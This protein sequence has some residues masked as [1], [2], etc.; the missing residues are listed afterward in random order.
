MTFE[1][2]RSLISDTIFNISLNAQAKVDKDFKKDIDNSIYIISKSFLILDTILNHT[3]QEKVSDRVFDSQAILW[4]GGNSLIGSLQLIRQGYTLEP[5]FLMRYAIENLAMV[6]SFHTEN[7]ELYYQKFNNGDLSGE[8]CVGEAR[9][10]VKQIGPIYGLLSEVT[11][12]SK[13]TLGYLYMLERKTVLI[14]GGVTD[15]TLHRVKMNLAI[16]QFLSNIYWSSS[17]LIFSDYLDKYTFWSKD[18]DIMKWAPKEEEKDIYERSLSLFQEAI[19]ALTQK[20]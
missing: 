17:E 4:Q 8:K 9:K 19:S 15:T 6:L 16:L 11:H 14:G 5:Q 2:L 1:E 3:D 20:S 10:L 13:K 18:G 7:A 12:P